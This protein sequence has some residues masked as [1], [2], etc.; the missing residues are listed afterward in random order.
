[1]RTT[2][3]RLF[4]AVRPIE[5]AAPAGGGKVAPGRERQPGAGRD[6]VAVISP[7]AGQGEG[8]QFDIGTAYSTER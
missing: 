7:T 1:M 8:N 4:T 5:D 2:R 6:A 3:H